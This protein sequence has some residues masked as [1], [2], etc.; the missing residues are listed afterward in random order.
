MR[1]APEDVGHGLALEVPL[2]SA[3]GA[4]EHARVGLPP[5]LP[6]WREPCRPEDASPKLKIII[7]TPVRRQS[8]PAAARVFLLPVAHRGRPTPTR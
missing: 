7:I 8:A 2:L 6:R 3:G 4:A 1:G 5:Q